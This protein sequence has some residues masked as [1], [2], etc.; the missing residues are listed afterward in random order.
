M[1]LT[2]LLFLSFFC[3]TYEI[4]SYKQHKITKY[5]AKKMSLNLFLD[6]ET[7]PPPSELKMKLKP[8]AINRLLRNFNSNKQIKPPS[9]APGKIDLTLQDAN[10]S[11]DCTNGC[12]EEMF[13]QLALHAEYGRIL[14]IGV[15]LE[16][17][18]TEIRK[19][20]FGFDKKTEKLHMDEAKTLRGFWKLLEKDFNP[21]RDLI[22][23]HNLM[24]FDLPFIYKRSR[25]KNIKPSVQLSFARYRS[26]PIFDTMR[27][28]AL[29]NLRE[30]SISL[31]ML[32]ELLE[33]GLKKTDGIDGSKV[34]DEY[35]SGSH[36]LIADYCL[37]DVEVTR[38]VYHRMISTDTRKDE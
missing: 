33:C 2:Q 28:W 16:K 7:V 24:D 13:R 37:Q 5:G 3:F 15:I 4:Q 12:T 9:D 31:S 26:A 17:D 27:E 23:G 10:N 25:I 38:A 22:I 30:T 6:I 1:N 35:L 18:G 8:D 29:W 11:N 19:G 32:A 14:C 36:C 34:Y 20:V 21:R